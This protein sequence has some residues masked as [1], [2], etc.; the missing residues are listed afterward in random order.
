[1][2]EFLG[3]YIGIK[4]DWLFNFCKD[5]IFSMCLFDN[6]IVDGNWVIEGGIED[7]FVRRDSVIEVVKYNCFE[8]FNFSLY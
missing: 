1:M 6:F 8:L 5:G 3:F 7:V 2:D 4:D